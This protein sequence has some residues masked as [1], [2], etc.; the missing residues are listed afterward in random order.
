MSYRDLGAYTDLVAFASSARGAPADELV[1]GD[2]ARAAVR[3]VLA[4]GVEREEALDLR[5]E[6]A[7]EAD[8]LRGEELS[9]GVG[10]GPRTRAW[11]LLPAGAR[12][13]RLPGVLALHDHGNFKLLGKEKIADGAEGP[14]GS[15]SVLRARAYGGAP[16]ANRLARL[17]FAVL[18][19][20]VFLWGSRGFAV[21]DVPERERE[22][23]SGAMRDA[24]AQGYTEDV[25]YA[26]AVAEM[27]EHVV[28]KICTVL[29][30][31]LAGIVAYEDRVALGVL[32]SR[33]EVDADRLGAVGLSG[34]GARAALLGA[35]HDALRAAA[36][37][38]MMSTYEGLLDR[39]VAR[40]TWMFF[41]PG[42]ARLGDW[43][44]LAACRAPRPLLVQYATEDALF[45]LAGMRAA[46][47]TLSRRYA[48][49]GRPAA[50][51][52]IFYRG[53]HRFDVPM[54]DDAFRWLA[55][56]L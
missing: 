2:A 15:V 55:S 40:H 54:Q 3:G 46:D 21:A 1:P 53:G 30:T 56:A 6:R 43:P 16:F 37:A 35:S 18:V 41:P 34:G 38:C 11:L 7:W 9:W 24:L 17:G 49:A 33:P 29:G 22:I 36:I 19:H 47:A 26:N 45:G 23:A 25:A 51:T 52:G 10:Y 14:S 5:V 50:Y 13:G 28:A 31:T 12:A 44:D 48:Q 4:F 42:L 32:A 8:G 27:H 20:D 39:H